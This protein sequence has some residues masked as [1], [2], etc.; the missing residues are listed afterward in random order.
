MEEQIEITCAH[1]GQEWSFHGDKAKIG[2][3]N[4]DSH[5]TYAQHEFTPVAEVVYN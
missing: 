1:C 3:H 4:M 5:E 2:R